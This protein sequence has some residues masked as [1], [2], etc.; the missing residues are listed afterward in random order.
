MLGASGRPRWGL[1]SAFFPLSASLSATVFREISS[2]SNT[3][4]SSQSVSSH[5]KA[6]TDF[7][8]DEHL[9]MQ[10]RTLIELMSVAVRASG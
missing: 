9:H 6:D 8:P 1:L 7:G 3:P 5:T 10:T 2:R 4:T